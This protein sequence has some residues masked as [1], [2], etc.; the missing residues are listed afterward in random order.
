MGERKQVWA[1]CYE[2]QRIVLASE[3]IAHLEGHGITEPVKMW[4]D[5]DPFVFDETLKPGDFEDER[6]SDGGERGE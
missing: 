5:G 2:C 3:L 4:P 6:A 1:K